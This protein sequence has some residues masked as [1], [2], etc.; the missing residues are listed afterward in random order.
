MITPKKENKK[1]EET[2]F[3]FDSEINKALFIQGVNEERKNLID[4]FD[5]LFNRSNEA[6]ASMIKKAQEAMASM[7]KDADKARVSMVKD[8]NETRAAMIEDI[9]EA[10]QFAEQSVEQARQETERQLRRFDE[11][12]EQSRQAVADAYANIPETVKASLRS[13]ID[14]AVD[15]AFK[16]NMEAMYKEKAAVADDFE[17]RTRRVQEEGGCVLVTHNQWN[18]MQCAIT[19]LAI[20]LGGIVTF[21]FRFNEPAI[22]K[23]AVLCALLY[24]LSLFIYTPRSSKKHEPGRG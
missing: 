19:V 24:A 6:M 8:A 2:K 7:I 18:L 4:R 3:D 11:K 16:R 12:V 9:N 10:E 20:F 14:T 15:A 5:Q 22:W 23:L 13:T 21:N 1:M 17:R